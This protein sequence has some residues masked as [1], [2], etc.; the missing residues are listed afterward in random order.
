MSR[1]ARYLREGVEDQLILE[2]A[3]GSE[4][5]S[6]EQLESR[7]VVPHHTIFYKFSRFIF[8]R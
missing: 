4:G 2:Q 3:K 1:Q 7:I 5:L 6:R 8:C